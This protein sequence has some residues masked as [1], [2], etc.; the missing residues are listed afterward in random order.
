MGHRRIPGLSVRLSPLAVAAGMVVALAAAAGCSSNPDTGATPVAPPITTTAVAVGPSTSPPAGA[1]TNIPP[2]TAAPTPMPSAAYPPL[3]GFGAVHELGSAVAISDA[4]AGTVL[5]LDRI[6][7]ITCPLQAGDPDPCLD[8]YRTRI[9]EGERRDFVVAP[10]VRF[11]Y[12]EQPEIYL[13]GGLAKLREFVANAPSN[14]VLL[15]LDQAGR[16]IA[17]GQPFLP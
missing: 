11:T 4:A 7:Y 17:V 3:S 10:E 15:Q 14:M 8:G 13:T 1:G 12:W 5:S 2:P 16:V 6:E 9:I